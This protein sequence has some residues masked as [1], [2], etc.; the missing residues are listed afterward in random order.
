MSDGFAGAAGSALKQMEAMPPEKYDLV[1][2]GSGPA[3]EKGAAQAAYF[4]KKVALVEKA[5]FLGG[6]AANTGTLPSKTL[7]ETA[8]FLTGF[9]QRQ[10]FGLDF[11]GLKESVT[12]RDFLMRERLVKETERARIQENLKRHNVVLYTG[13]ASFVDAHTMAVKPERCPA[14][15]IQGD[16]ILLATG[17][18][19]YRPPVFPFH[20]PRIYDSDTI[21]ALHEIPERLLVVGGGVVGCEYACTFAAMGVKVTVVEKRDRLIACLDAEIARALQTGMESLGIHFF[22][23]DSVDSVHTGEVLEVRLQSGTLVKSDTILVSSGRCGNTEE[24]ALEGVGIHVNERGQIKV[25][26][27]YQTTVPHVYAA[28]DVI[29]NPALASTSMEQARVAM[30]HAFN[31]KYKEHVA[32]ILPTGIF[33]IPECSMVGETEEALVQ[34]KI[35]YVVGKASYEKNARGQIIGDQAGLL[36]LLFH[37]E[38]MRL[39]GVHM[40]G[41]QATELIHVGLTALL[42][43]GGADL[44]IQSCYNYPTLSELYK[45]AAYDALGRSAKR[46]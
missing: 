19:P 28:G 37:E 3:G 25:N 29:G 46:Q 32:P 5:M 7:R 41:E 44:F 42:Q 2:I 27:Q 13:S 1:V 6:A 30:V 34:K 45:Y 23:N 39:L 9:R 12:V 36:K 15:L 33:T 21:L 43:K 24:L 16:I 4:G 31:L 40:V 17:S 22:L 26:D 11:R 38:N 14:F 18:Y 35:P 20:D 10:L 8:L